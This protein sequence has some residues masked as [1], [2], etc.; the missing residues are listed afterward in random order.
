[1]IE[2]HNGSLSYSG[3]TKVIYKGKKFTAPVDISILYAW[4]Y[5]THLLETGEYKK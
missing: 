4:N 2:I 5:I 1:M 3:Y